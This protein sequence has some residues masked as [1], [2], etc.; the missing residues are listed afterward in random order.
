MIRH[1]STALSAVGVIAAGQLLL[2]LPFE[3]DRAED[4]RIVIA[5]LLTLALGSFAG[6]VAL[7]AVVLTILMILTRGR[8]A[9][10]WRN[11]SQ[12]TT[13]G[14]WITNEW[15]FVGNDG[16]QEGE[17]LFGLAVAVQGSPK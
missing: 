13:F 11:P 14:H 3:P 15:H 4:G 1:L 6:F 8:G 7:R 17:C 9:V 2:S 16:M 12:C 10:A 5:A